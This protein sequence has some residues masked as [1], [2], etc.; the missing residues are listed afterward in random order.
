MLSAKTPPRV[1]LVDPDDQQ[2]RAAARVLRDHGCE[3]M[4]VSGSEAGREVLAR[5]P[6]AAVITAMRLDDGNGLDMV[7]AVR[8]LQPG[9]PVLIALG[10]SLQD[11][12][13]AAKVMSFSNHADSPLFDVLDAACHARAR[14]QVSRS[15]RATAPLT[16]AQAA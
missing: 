14:R 4:V 16:Y 11:D 7:S 10:V 6:I 12:R 3:I 1:L 15:R 5:Y 9:I 2:A 8:R 13:V